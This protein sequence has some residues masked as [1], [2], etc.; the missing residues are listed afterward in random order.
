MKKCVFVPGDKDY[1]DFAVLC[2][3]IL[4]NFLV[5]VEVVREVDLNFSYSYKII[6]MIL[7]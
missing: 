2:K 3:K 5:E 4:F 7:I 6:K 1:K